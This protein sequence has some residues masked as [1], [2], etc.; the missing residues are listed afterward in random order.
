MERKLRIQI[1][2]QPDDTTC[3]PTALHAVY[4]YHGDPISLRRVTTETHVLESGGTL[5]VLLAIHALKRGY[6][7]D[8]HTYNLQLFDPSW[9]RRKPGELARK[10][11]AQACASTSQRLHLATRAY[12]EY[13]ELGG[14]LHFE[15]LEPDLLA[16]LMSGST[17]VL[18][19]LSSTYL[20]Q[21]KRERGW[22]NEWDDIHGSPQ[23]HFVVL[24]GFD[25]ERKLV[26]VA[27]PLYPKPASRDGLYTVPVHRLINSILLGVLTYD[28][29]LLVLKP[30]PKAAA[31]IRESRQEPLRGKDGRND[32]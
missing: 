27:D 25:P 2:K 5:A 14:R 29:N 6:E 31:A 17:P 19:G 24:A 12:L 16:R 13:L 20:Y 1:L 30:G 15:D 7:A 18:T 26:L 10:L 32:P 28:A 3:G 22:D 21:H 23:G 8:L 11:R 4:R 9:F